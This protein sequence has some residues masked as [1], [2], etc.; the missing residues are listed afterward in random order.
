M[1]FCTKTSAQSLPL[2]DSNNG[3]FNFVATGG[4]LRSQPNGTN[5][6]SRITTSTANL[7]G[8]PS[9]ATVTKAYLYWAGSGQTADNSITFDGT[10]YTADR[11]YSAIYNL[12][13]NSFHFFAA[14]KDVTS[15]VQSRRNASYAFTN[16]TFQTA[17]STNQ[18]YCSQQAVMG[19]WGLYVVYEDPNETAKRVNFY[20]GFETFRNSS[21]SYNLNGLSVPPAPQGKM[22]VLAWEGDPTL[23]GGG[24]NFT[25]NGTSLVDALNPL[26]NVYNS[27][28]N[29]LNSSTTYGVDLDTFDV[30]AFLVPGQ[31]FASAVVTSGSDLVLLNVVVLSASTMV[32]DLELSKTVN[33]PNPAEGQ[34]VT[35]TINLFNR[36]PDNSGAAQ[37]RDLL[38]AGL[39]FVSANSTVGSYNSTTGIW[40][41][42][43]LAVNSTATLT[44]NASVN[45]GTAGTTIVNA[46]EVISA[47]TFDPDSTEN[48]GNNGEDDY[49]SIGI[50][51]KPNADLAIVKTGPANANL[52]G[53]INYSIQVSNAG[54]NNVTG[55][56]I[57]DVVPSS[58][59]VTNWTCT[60]T[61]AAVCGTA[62]GT[63][64]NIS[65]T[66]NINSGASNRITINVVGTINTATTISNTA[67]VA[68]PVSLND[69]NPANNTSTAITI[70]GLSVSG[71]VWHDVNGSANGTFSN[72]QNGAEIGTNA[73]GLFAIAVNAAGNVIS[74]VAVNP[75]GTYSI[76]GIPV[77]STNITIRI[78][79]STAAAGQPA[80]AVSL[81][82]GWTNTSPLATANFNTAAA[83][84]TARDFGIEQLPTANGLTAPSQPNPSGTVSVFA[85]SGIFTGTDPDGTISSFTFSA[86]PS[87][88]T[89][90]TISGTT[91]NSSNFPAAGVIINALAN[92]SLPANTISIDPIDG[93]VS[94]NIPFRVTDNAG[95]ASLL[96]A[97][98]VVP[99]SNSLPPNV[100][101]VKSCSAPANCETA[102]QLPGTDLTYTIVFTNSGGQAAQGLIIVDGIPANTDFKVGSTGESL[103]AGLSFLVEYSYDYTSGNPSIATWTALPPANPGGGAPVGYNSLVRAVRWR[104]VSGSLSNISPNN[105]GSVNFT[106]RIR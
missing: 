7:T 57:A 80:P 41:V 4:T 25:F 78:A 77:N 72:I 26:G 58:I 22:S 85:P 9:T 6:C 82:A 54:T 99:F 33:I 98:A 18:P 1:C 68:V 71:T 66:G 93:P 8:I 56:T 97:I 101:L 39:T 32:A 28:I 17:D 27:T 35:Y 104:N 89:T 63:T 34:T 20:E 46:A 96:A 91:Y 74:S 31:N 30:G 103:P 88:V 102:N 43:S 59:T 15:K 60:V 84:I 76:G 100:S 40:S 87:N 44:I 24:E 106:V 12:S 14:V 62:S 45:P 73:G 42:S 50:N 79:T 49:S 83:N 2:L 95:K 69:T 13:P 16:L 55:L 36:G 3:R 64:N 52:G 81:P 90:V 37:I 23:S 94:V 67:T 105:T 65:L 53:P 21:Q 92:G 11:T 51:V 38:P 5:A 48:N 19:G 86:F 75:N 61:G 70:V 29:T 10:N 47:D